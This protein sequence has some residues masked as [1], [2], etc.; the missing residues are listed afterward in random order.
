VASL[1]RN[2]LYL[3]GAR[4]LDVTLYAL[5]GLILPRHVSTETNGVY[6]LVSTL[7]FFGS[8]A[9][10]FGI[11]LVF[12]RSVARHPE[13]SARLY[14]DARTAMLGGA[15]LAGVG[16]LA[17]VLLEQGVQG[18]AD[19]SRYHFVAFAIA[20]LF[21]DAL[22]MAAES[23]FQAHEE[24]VVPARVSVLTGLLRAGGG[25]AALL[26]LSPGVPPAGAAPDWGRGS[27]Y[28]VYAC[29]LLGA[30]I[31]AWFLPRMARRRFLP[32]ELPRPEAASA[33]SLLRESLGVALFRMLRMVRNRIDMQLLGLLIPAAAL[34]GLSALEAVDKARGLYGQAF[35]VVLVFHTLTMAFNTALFP[36]MARLTG[37]GRGPEEVR[38]LFFR[39]VRYQAWWA[40]P[41]AAVTFLYAP[42]VAGWFGEEYRQGVAGLGSTTGVLRILAVAMLLD[43]IGGP[44]GMLLIGQKEMD[45]KLPWFGAALA[46]TS[47]A[48]NVLLIPRYG[49]HGAAWASLTASAVE[50]LVKLILIRRFLGSPWPMLPAILPY[51]LLAAGGAVGLTLTPL[52]AHPILGGL[53]LAAAFLLLTLALGLVDPA[54]VSRLRR[55]G[56]G[57][58]EAA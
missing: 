24:M 8:M 20:I 54:V 34:G 11:P 3:T 2:T 42:Q 47:V 27:L 19:P 1:A 51:L 30:G 28:G 37:S 35:R 33:W 52:A 45:R 39:A 46:V 12:V 21:C 41:L 22:S 58:G 6:S 9:A 18:E 4:L 5:F 10:S 32:G 16:M 14:V 43:T 55:L 40:A 25:I 29:F 56:G 48:A 13:R 44:V 15:A 23:L 53:T 36:R 17:W 7:L 50:F 31:R 38:P 26:L 57:G 49:I